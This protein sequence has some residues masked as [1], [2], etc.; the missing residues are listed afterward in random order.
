MKRSNETKN[1]SP[2][3]LMVKQ[4]DRYEFVSYYLGCEKSKENPCEVYGMERANHIV[5]ET[6]RN[7]KFVKA[8]LYD[9]LDTENK[10]PQIGVFDTN[11]MQWTFKESHQHLYQKQYGTP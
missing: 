4:N 11:T 10:R 6:I 2:L 7:G 3:K 8:W 9:N 5:K 1:L